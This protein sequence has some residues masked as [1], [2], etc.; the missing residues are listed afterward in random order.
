MADGSLIFDTKV[1]D[2][3]FKKGMSKLK[4]TGTTAMKVV[5]KGIVATGAAL[6]AMGGYTLKASIDFESAFAGVRKTIDATEAEFAMLE[7][8]IRDMSKKMPQSASAIAE[9]AEAAGQLGIRT[10]NILGFTETMVMLGDATNMSSDQAATALARLANITGMSQ[11]DFDRLGSTIVELGN[12]LATTEA[13]IVEMG[14]RLAGT[15][16]QVG[17]T[18]HEMLALA[19]AMS[20]VG[21]NAEAGGSSMSRVMQKINTEVLSGGKNLSKFAEISG[22]SSDEFSKAWKDKPAEAITAFIN[23]L[24]EVNASGGDVTT[25]LK[26]LGINSVQ[27]IDTLL[28][29]SGA[30]DVLTDALGMSA[31]AWEEN[32]ALADEASQRYETTES[33]IQIL[34]NNIDDLAKSV[35]DGLKE[36]FRGGIGTAIEMVQQLADA[37][38]QGGI[39]GF[40]EEIGSMLADM[41]TK[42]AEFI[43]KML[44][45]GTDLMLS[46]INGIKNNKEQLIQA[47]LDILQ[48]F[49]NAFLTVL[50]EMIV[51][52]IEMLTGFMQGFV[53][54]LPE[55]IAQSQNVIMT[56]VNSIV[57]NLPIMLESGIQIIVMLAQGIAEML[58]ELITQFIDLVIMLSDTIIEN[59]PMLIEAGLQII[60]AIVQG[61]IENL[62]TLIEHVPRIINAFFDAIIE[63]LPQIIQAGIQ[64]IGMLIMGIIQS[65]P[66]LIA[67]IPAIVRAIVNV[68]T[69]YNWAKLGSNI[70]TWLK[71][72]IK[73]MPGKIAEAGKEVAKAGWEAIKGIFKDAPSLGKGFIRWLINGIMSMLGSLASSAGS[74]AKAAWNAILGIFKNAPSMGKNF[75]SWLRNGISS[76]TG[77]LSGTARQISIAA[78]RAVKNIFTG[79]PGI[80]KQFVKGLWSGIASLTGWIGKQIAGFAKGLVKKFKDFFKIHSPSKLMEDVIGRNLILGIGVGIEDET[81]ELNNTVDKEMSSLT[82]QMKATVDLETAKLGVQISASS[83]VDRVSRR[84]VEDDANSKSNQMQGNVYTVIEI[85]GREVARTITPYTSKELARLTKGRR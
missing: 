85:D 28:R 68:I 6:T 4:S 48:S 71:D 37:F 61:L 56:I 9:V 34:K 23:G 46:F 27:E 62:P 1:D 30:S 63:N 79:M 70:M 66:T 19:G 57:Q 39:E 7:K 43:P 84:T 74:L 13:E 42:V 17:L 11:N 54:M 36:S 67:N 55:L 32:T 60:L 24:D 65:I 22:M 8:G 75:I 10:E 77:N 44:D 59:L 47:T 14:L 49:V 50:P 21:I 40:V 78:M 33:M 41:L 58:P 64:L 35:G 52:G 51:L 16:S 3:G 29:L 76:M 82:K 31:K 53:K 45:T 18:E 73:K 25:M 26:E 83:N 80:G 12:N 38:E 81:P 5:A 72:G 20:S 15:A 2:K 69:M